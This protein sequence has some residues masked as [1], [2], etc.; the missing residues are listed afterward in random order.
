MSTSPELTNL[1]LLGGEIEVG[2]Q[3]GRNLPPR[4]NAQIVRNLLRIYRCRLSLDKGLPEDQHRSRESEIA[5]RTSRL[6]A[7]DI[8]VPNTLDGLAALIHHFG[9]KV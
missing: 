5:R 7:S 8:E 6:K 1:A 2:N 3:Y 4:T 9:G